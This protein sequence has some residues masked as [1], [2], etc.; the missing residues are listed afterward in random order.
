MLLQAYLTHK[1]KV[2][3]LRAII[4][5]PSRLES[6]TLVFAY[7]IDLF[8]VRTAP[9]KVFDSLTEDFSFALLLSTVVVLLIGIVVAWWI[10]GRQELRRKWK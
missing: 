8:F 6:T 7:G 2:E 4:S 1:H 5:E 3:G 10:A 9:S